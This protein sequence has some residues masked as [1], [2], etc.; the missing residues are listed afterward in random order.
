MV[1][2]Q[3]LFLYIHKNIHTHTHTLIYT[4]LNRQKMKILTSL[5]VVCCFRR[6]KNSFS[7]LFFRFSF[8]TEDGRYFALHKCPRNVRIGQ[9]TFLAARTIDFR[10]SSLSFNTFSGARE[11]EFMMR[12]RRTL[13][14][15]R[16]FKALLA[17]GTF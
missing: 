10:T 12:N 6:R 1:S 17:Q 16:I 5:K 8:F 3:I 4:R 14:K 7:S 2:R 11:A 9:R 13:N 15:M